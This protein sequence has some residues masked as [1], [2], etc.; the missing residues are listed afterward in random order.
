MTRAA[1]FRGF[2]LLRLALLSLCTAP[3]LAAPQALI[4]LLVANTGAIYVND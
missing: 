1:F 4:D 2:N 3:A